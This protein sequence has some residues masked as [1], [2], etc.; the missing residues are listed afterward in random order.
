MWKVETLAHII[1][2]QQT[3]TLIL[4]TNFER[5]KVTKPITEAHCSQE[6]V[7]EAPDFTKH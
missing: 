5:S 1:N 2:A 7:P 6:I 4:C 3:L